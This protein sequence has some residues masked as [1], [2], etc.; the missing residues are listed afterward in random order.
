MWF[1]RLYRSAR[2][3]RAF[4]RRTRCPPRAGAAESQHLF[5]FFR[6]SPGRGAGANVNVET[7][8]G[9]TNLHG[10]A[11]YFGRNETLDANNFFANATGVPKGEFRR[12][13]PGGTLGGPLPWLKKRAFFFVSY[14]ATRDVNAASLDS[15]IRTLS[16]P[17]IPQARTPASLGAVFGGQT[18][19]FGA[20]FPALPPR[21]FLV[22]IQRC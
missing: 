6:P 21:D 1:F 4:I 15:S 22:G 16:L 13:Q 3:L 2:G 9:T 20:T 10:S 19:A 8:S 5:Q 12:S 14:Q 17:P 18:G 7:R 11:Y